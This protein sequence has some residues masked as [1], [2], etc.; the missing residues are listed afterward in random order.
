MEKEL[1]LMD[2]D[3][4]KNIMKPLEKAK[5]KHNVGRPKKELHTK[6]SDRITCKICGK[7]YMRSNSS[8]HKKTNHHKLHE[9]MNNKIRDILINK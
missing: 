7:E 8:S 1:V 4:L 6:W 9:Q 2:K 5:Y 3:E